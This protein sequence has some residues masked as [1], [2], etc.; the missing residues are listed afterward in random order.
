MAIKIPKISGVCDPIFYRY[1]H[2]KKI[3][4]FF[5]K[6]NKKKPKI[7]YTIRCSNNSSTSFVYNG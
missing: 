6:F 5:I 4:C 1:L 3:V 7:S 2:D